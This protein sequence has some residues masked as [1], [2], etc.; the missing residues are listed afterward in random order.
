MWRFRGFFRIAATP[1]KD[2]ATNLRYSHKIPHFEKQVSYI[3]VHFV[4][5]FS[6]IHVEGEI[7]LYT[8]KERIQVRSYFQMLSKI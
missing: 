3:A 6:Q 1:H 5:V 8:N 7:Y 2:F 4:I